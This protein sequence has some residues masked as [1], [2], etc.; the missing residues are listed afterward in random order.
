M[1]ILD[2]IFDIVLYFFSFFFSCFYFCWILFSTFCNYVQQFLSNLQLSTLGLNYIEKNLIDFRLYRPYKG[3]SSVRPW[4]RI[5]IISAYAYKPFIKSLF[6][7]QRG[8]HLTGNTRF[9]AGRVEHCGRFCR[10]SSK[11][12]LFCTCKAIHNW[13]LFSLFKVYLGEFSYLHFMQLFSQTLG[14]FYK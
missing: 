10:K 1:G 11:S 12:W 14:Y 8:R 7:R 3:G 13:W 9:R 4:K 5:T 6:L 2:K